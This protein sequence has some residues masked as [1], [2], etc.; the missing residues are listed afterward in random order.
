MPVVNVDGYIYSHTTVSKAWRV[1]CKTLGSPGT[2]SERQ[3]LLM[4]SELDSP[5]R[6]VWARD[7]VGSIRCIL[8][9]HIKR[10]RL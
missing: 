5:D 6:E 3:A 4:I 8:G 9:N 2:G 10:D 7:L 1:Q